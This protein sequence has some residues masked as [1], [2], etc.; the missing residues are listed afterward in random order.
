MF[1][2]TSQDRHGVATSV[3]V[4]MSRNVIENE[5]NVAHCLNAN[6][7][8]KFFWQESKRKCGS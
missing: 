5:I 1:T 2:L 4:S 7:S 6:D 8:R 3:P